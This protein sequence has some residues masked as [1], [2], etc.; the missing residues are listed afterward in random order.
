MQNQA[1]TLQTARDGQT[2]ENLSQEEA[3]QA[4]R[5]AMRGQSPFGNEPRS[6]SMQQSHADDVRVAA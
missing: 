4:I 5:R 3:A 1:W 2:R 6:I